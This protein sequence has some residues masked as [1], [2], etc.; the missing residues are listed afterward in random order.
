MFTSIGIEKETACCFTGHRRLSKEEALGLRSLLRREIA[1]LAIGKGVD[2]FLTGGA[3]GFDTLAAQETLRAKEE[4][5]WL[6]LTLVLPCRGQ[7]ARWP[8]RDRAVY[9]TLQRQADD[10]LFLADTYF[11]GC[12]HARNR[13]LVDHSAY[14]LCYLRDTARGGTAYTVRYARK[15]GAQAVNLFEPD[16]DAWGDWGP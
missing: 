9:Q 16:W 5:P 7:E 15:R 12:M 10:V 6:R 14:C 2:H 4:F 13:F 11:E 1:R 8:P 3:L